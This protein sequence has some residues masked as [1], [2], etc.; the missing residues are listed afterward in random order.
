MHQR[1][2]GHAELRRVR[3][4]LRD[5]A[6]LSVGR[7]RLWHG[8]L[9]MC[10]KLRV[11]EQRELWCLRHDLQQHAGVQQQ[12]LRV[13]LCQRDDRLLERHLR[14]PSDRQRKLRELRDGLFG[15][16]DLHLGFLHLRGG[17]PAA[18]RLGLHGHHQ[19]HRQ[20]R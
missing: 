19:Q 16:L 11:V 14:Q 13:E 8:P 5:G 2:D 10:R 7:L 20:L 17:R 9:E 4:G 15:R 1:A 6:D 12:R 3:H 18:L